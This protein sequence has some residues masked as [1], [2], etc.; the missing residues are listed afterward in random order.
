MARTM[1]IPHDI[2]MRLILLGAYIAAVASFVACG[3]LLAGLRGRRPD[4]VVWYSGS[5]LGIGILGVPFGLAAIG[6]SLLHVKGWEGAVSWWF[7]VAGFLLSALTALIVF[8]Y[9]VVILPDALVE[10]RVFRIGV[11]RIPWNSIKSWRPGRRAGSVILETS[12]DFSFAPIFKDG[13]DAL[14]DA[15]DEHQIPSTNQTTAG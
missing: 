10:T 15:I 14:F 6:A 7:G 2:A 12:P 13:S 8:R 3:N 11:R 9:R 4:Q 1:A 5:V